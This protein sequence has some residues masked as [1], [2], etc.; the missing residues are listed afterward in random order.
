MVHVIAI[1]LDCGIW[2]R[3]WWWQAQKL[4]GHPSPSGL[5]TLDPISL[6]RE[7]AK[8]AKAKHI[9]GLVGKSM[10]PFFLDM[11]DRVW[12]RLPWIDCKDSRNA[13]ID[14]QG[15]SKNSWMELLSHY[16]KLSH[17]FAQ[18]GW[19]QYAR[20]SLFLKL[21]CL[22]A[23]WFICFATSKVWL[24]LVWCHQIGLN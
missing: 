14:H 10:K 17:L 18:V 19:T 4:F 24:L 8:C 5:C 9:C 1:H 6:T 12:V 15:D 13:W 20:T 3:W 22:D 16:R 21:C 7:H 23:N 11:T 2:K